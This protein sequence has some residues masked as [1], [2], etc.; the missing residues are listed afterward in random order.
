MIK[1]IA[2]LFEWYL[3]FTRSRS[4]FAT[5]SDRLIVNLGMIMVWEG[6]YLK[7]IKN[8]MSKDEKA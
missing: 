1:L 6:V 8:K 5:S 7:L 4:S 2:P 3:F